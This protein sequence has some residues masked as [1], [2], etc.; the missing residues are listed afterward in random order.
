VKEIPG[1]MRVRM[2]AVVNLLQ[3]CRSAVMAPR[4]LSSILGHSGFKPLI[5]GL[6]YCLFNAGAVI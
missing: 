4:P 2:H 6:P 3:E 5:N 1:G